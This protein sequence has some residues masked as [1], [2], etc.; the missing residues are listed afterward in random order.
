[1]ADVPRKSPPTSGVRFRRSQDAILPSRVHAVAHYL[2]YVCFVAGV[3]HDG[4]AEVVGFEERDP[5][6]EGVLVLRAGDATQS[7]SYVC[8]SERGVLDAAY[9]DDV[10]V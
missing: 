2:A 5:D 7:F 3:L 10:P 8:G 6:V 9:F 4:R 1:M